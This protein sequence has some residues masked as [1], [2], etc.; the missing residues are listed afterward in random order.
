MLADKLTR[1]I[2]LNRIETPRRPYCPVYPL[3]SY[4]RLLVLLKV[5][6]DEP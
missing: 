5:I 2:H 4:S 3:T 1:G 6:V